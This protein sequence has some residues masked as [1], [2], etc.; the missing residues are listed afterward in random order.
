M[1]GIRF[2]IQNGRIVEG[3]QKIADYFSSLKDGD[4]MLNVFTSDPLVTEEDYR[5]AYFKLIDI[6]VAESGND[7]D[8]IHKAYKKYQKIEST[9]DFNIVEWKKYLENFK[10]WLYNNLNIIC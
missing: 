7:K 2:K 10:L 5:A 3:K 4:F 8:T 6:A 9:K 1:Q